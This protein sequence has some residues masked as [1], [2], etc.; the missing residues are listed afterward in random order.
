MTNYKGEELQLTYNARGAKTGLTDAN[1][2]LWDPENIKVI[3]GV[4]GTELANGKYRQAYTPTKIGNYTG[5]WNSATYPFRQN[6]EF[7]VVAVLRQGV[8]G[9]GLIYPIWSKGE[10]EKL[11]KLMEEIEKILKLQKKSNKKFSAKHSDF[12][13]SMVSTISSI[14]TENA[15]IKA[16]IRNLNSKIEKDHKDNELRDKIFLEL[17]PI[18]VLARV[19]DKNE[20]G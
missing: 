5:Y 1:L 9:G 11:M 19:L 4:A 8:G 13:Q 16:E 10:K 20:K 12:Q 15:D 3:D 7:R 18:D 17:A 6:V 2:H 14:E